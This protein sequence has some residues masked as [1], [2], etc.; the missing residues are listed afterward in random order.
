MDSAYIDAH[1]EVLLNGADPAE[2]LDQA[3]TAIQSELDSLL[4]Q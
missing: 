2:M 4:N 3:E 1:S